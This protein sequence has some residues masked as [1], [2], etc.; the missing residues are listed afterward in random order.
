MRSL[1]FR[2]LSTAWLAV[3]LAPATGAEITQIVFPPADVILEGKI[4]PGDYEKLLKLIYLINEDCGENKYCARGIYLASPGGSLV[5][6]MKIGRLG[7][8]VAMGDG[9]TVSHY[10]PVCEDGKYFKVARTSRSKV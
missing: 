7:A 2:A 10:K 4:E 9:R 8:S 1:I 5:E 3:L 6:A